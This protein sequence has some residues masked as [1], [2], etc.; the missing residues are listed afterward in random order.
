MDKIV[1]KIGIFIWNQGGRLSRAIDL[2]GLI[3]KFTKA[4]NV[5]RCEIVDELWTTAFFDSLK[6]SVANKQVDRFLWVGR[7]TPYQMKYLKDQLSAAGL[8]PYL[9]EWTD[10]EE[11]G[12]C[13]KEA[14]P[15]VRAAKAATLIQMVLARTR[16]LEPLE[17]MELPASDAILI[18][19]AGVAGLHA[20]ESLAALGKH[21]H[22]VE[23]ES[24]VGGKVALLSRFYPRICDPH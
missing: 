20:A 16:L 19:G 13:L 24:G 15:E 2:E 14:A 12:I 11:Q 23:K 22:L 17:P 4:K 6:N 3:K 5:A 9:H 18:I 21:V 7:F 8:N 1:P 10:L